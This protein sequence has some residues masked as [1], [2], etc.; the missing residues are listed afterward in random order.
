[1]K[2]GWIHPKLKIDEFEQAGSASHAPPGVRFL[3]N[4]KAGC[5]EEGTST[6]LL[7]PD[8]VTASSRATSE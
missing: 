3:W 7:G 8:T 4:S 2:A 1:M 6:A 5:L